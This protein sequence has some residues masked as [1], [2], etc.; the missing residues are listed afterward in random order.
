MTQVLPKLLTFNEFIE[1]YPNDGKR[2]ELH[3]GVIIE[4]PPPTGSHEKVVGFIA[5]KLTVEFDRLNLPYTIPKT[6]SI[7]TPSAESAYSPDVL[8][9]NLDNLDNEP[10]FQKQ[11][12]VSLAASVPIVIEVVS[13]N[14]RDDYYNKLRDYEEM[15]IPEY[16]IADYAALG[17]RKFI[18]NPK[19]PTIFVCELV[20][21][22]YQMI[23]FQ[24]NTAISSPTFPQLN[25]TA[26]QIFNVAN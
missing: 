10:L 8:L 17:A 25:L 12:T 7:K 2:Y 24:G 26:Q 14:W 20:D 13:S 1:W 22:E 23:S 3:K 16:W 9:L 15:G 11:S 5:H 6:V 18:G 19:Q 4:M 21:G